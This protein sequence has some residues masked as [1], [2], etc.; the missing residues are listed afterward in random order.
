MFNIFH[1][2]QM[3]N[4]VFTGQKMLLNWNCIIS[5]FFWRVLISIFVWLWMF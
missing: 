1:K 3:C 5:F 2:K 4:S